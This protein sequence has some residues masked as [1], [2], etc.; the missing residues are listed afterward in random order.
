MR[1]WRF[2]ALLVIVVA[3]V[4]SVVWLTF[5]RAVPPASTPTI[6]ERM[7]ALHFDLGPEE[8]IRFIPLPGAP[9]RFGVLSRQLVGF[10]PAQEAGCAIF[11]RTG[12]MR[13]PLGLSTGRLPEAVRECLS[14]ENLLLDA[15]PELEE[16]LIPGD[17]VVRT[18]AP[19]DARMAALQTIL[20]DRLHRPIK[21]LLRDVDRFVLREE[22]VTTTP[23]G[24]P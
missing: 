2:I 5:P 6:A 17:W 24:K 7:F 12:K 23:A 19:R 3:A 14:S 13:T 18:D 10:T 8:E 4:A 1:Q 21:I 11:F 20:R 16:V 9:M 22:G 15:P